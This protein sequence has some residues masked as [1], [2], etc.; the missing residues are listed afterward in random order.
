MRD[1]RAAEE[2]AAE[3][4]EK[5]RWRASRTE[6]EVGWVVA[7]VATERAEEMEVRRPRELGIRGDVGDVE[8]DEV[9]WAISA[10]TATGSSGVGLGGRHG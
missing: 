6:R 3:R 5:V 8:G 2:A 10:V 1:E 9:S 4:V 7:T